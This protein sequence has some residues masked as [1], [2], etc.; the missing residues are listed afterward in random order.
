MSKIA[1]VLV[2]GKTHTTA[3]D[4]R[5]ISGNHEGNVNIK[6]SSPGISAAREHVFPATCP[7]LR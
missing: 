1:K 4:A 2:T 3:S 6:L 7:V 5:I